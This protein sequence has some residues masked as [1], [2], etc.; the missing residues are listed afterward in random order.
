MNKKSKK[1]EK[2]LK[3][4]VMVKDKVKKES[5][6]KMVENLL[7]KFAEKYYI[8]YG[9]R[10]IICGTCFLL[11]IGLSFLLL[12]KSLDI[13]EGKTTRYQETGSMDY[14][15]YLKP[16]EFYETPY[17]N[18]NMYYIASLIK[19]INVDLNYQFII[20][21][22]VD[23]NF[24]Y[25][26]VAKLKIA[27]NQGKDKLYEKE[28]VLVDKK[29]NPST[30]T[31]VQNIKES[32]VIDYDYYNELA[33]K[34]GAT[35]GVSAASD[36]TLS[37]RINKSAQNNEKE[38]NINEYS[39]MSLTIPLTQKTLS[40]QLNDTGINS[41][42]SIVKEDKITFSNIFCGI[43]SF[44]IFVL[45]VGFIL[46]TLELLF[47][48]VPKTSKYDKYIKKILNEYDR[49]I[50]ETPTSPRTENKDIVKIKRFEELLDARDSLKRPIM[51]HSLVEHQK[52]YFY[53]EQDNT[54]YLLTIKATDLEEPLKKAKNK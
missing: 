25:Q 37:V 18:K 30:N 45:S 10:V 28:Y 29:L 43:M 7:N 4:E 19:S 9:A 22:P 49:L 44:L 54:M 15:V 21:E 35:F 51:Y 6:L 16:N 52:C 39:N 26:V 11:L 5:P 12:I 24:S 53:I 48:L 34:F 33:N 46:K 27:G 1:S 13:E 32:V 40:I 17:L 20:E 8:G 2:K 38:I 14:K 36:L 3:K 50:V 31:N 47:M 41:T 42:K 23:T